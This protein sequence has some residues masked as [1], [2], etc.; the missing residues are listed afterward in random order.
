PQ[1][2]PRPTL[3]PYTPLFRS[4]LPAHRRHGFDHPGRACRV[5]ERGT[6]GGDELR[7]APVATC[8]ILRERLPEDRVEL[9]RQ[10]G[11]RVAHRRNLDRKS[12]RLNSSH[13]AISYA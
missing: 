1:P 3:F 8:R 10:L 2:P 5:V 9:A 4:R 6:K 11:V 13:V 7:A 12:T